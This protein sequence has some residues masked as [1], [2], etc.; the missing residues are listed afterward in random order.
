[1]KESTLKTIIAGSIA[2]LAAY[3]QLL[4]VPIAVLVT[5]M[6]FDYLSGMAAAWAAKNLSSRIGV[7]GIIK[8]V[9]YL[10]V[11]AVGMVVDYIIQAVGAQLGLD[12]SG[13]FIFGLLVIVWLILNELISILENLSEIGIPLPVFLE[14]IIEKLKSQAEARSISLIQALSS[15]VVDNSEEAIYKTALTAL[16]IELEDISTSALEELATQRLKIPLN[17][18]ETKPAIIALISAVL[19][20]EN[21]NT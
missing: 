8:K 11:V 4:I 10:L 21:S 2:A 5:V 9:C 16:G 7:F 19:E 13:Y 6:I 12:L 1:M 15:G 20:K 18:T 3:F 17:G 14:K